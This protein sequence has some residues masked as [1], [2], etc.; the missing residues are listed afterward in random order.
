MSHILQ[1]NTINKNTALLLVSSGTDADYVPA[2]S[3]ALNIIKEKFRSELYGIQIYDAI[4]NA[5]LLHTMNRAARAGAQTVEHFISVQEALERIKTDGYMTTYV[6]P[7]F[8]LPGRDT[9]AMDEEIDARISYGCF[10]SI[11][12]GTSLPYTLC[13]LRKL[14]GSICVPGSSDF[15]SELDAV[16]DALRSALRSDA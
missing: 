6:Q 16:I 1:D 2:Y 4:A 11:Y 10:S 3:Q 15:I 5:K 12:R 14:S 9:D 8:L 13:D 7:L